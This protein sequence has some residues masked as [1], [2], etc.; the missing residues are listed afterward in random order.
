MPN[1][2]GLAAGKLAHLM[3]SAAELLAVSTW[4]VVPTSR[5]T[6]LVPL[7]VNSCPA[8]VKRLIALAE[9]PTAIT[10]LLSM[11]T[12]EVAVPDGC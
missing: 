2:V 12:T 1:N 6:D 11:E 5:A 9:P 8:S 4:P 7:E 10:L 3:P